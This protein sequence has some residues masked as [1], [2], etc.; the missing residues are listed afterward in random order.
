M[1]I[2]PADEGLMRDDHSP[3]SYSKSEKT[4]NRAYRRKRS[5]GSEESDNE[6]QLEANQQKAVKRSPSPEVES[7]RVSVNLRR[8]PQRRRSV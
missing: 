2:K 7:R 3:T 8:S 4:Q 5:E 1:K 6:P